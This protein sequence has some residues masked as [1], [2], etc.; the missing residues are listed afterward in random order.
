MA[1]S[2]SDSIRSTLCDYDSAS[3]GK[4]SAVLISVSADTCRILEI[5]VVSICN[6]L[7][8]ALDYQFLAFGKMD[9]AVDCQCRTLFKD[10]QD[11]TCSCYF[12]T[13]VYCCVC[14]SF[15]AISANKLIGLVGNRNPYIICPDSIEGDI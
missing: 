14:G 4:I 6:E 5:A 15:I 11:C 12:N 9:T 2:D 13:S 10:K 3:D 1:G 8:L 7:S